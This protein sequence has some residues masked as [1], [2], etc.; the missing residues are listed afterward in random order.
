LNPFFSHFL[1]FSAFSSRFIPFLCPDAF[2]FPLN[3]RVMCFFQDRKVLLIVSLLSG[4]YERNQATMF[5]IATQTW[6]NLPSMRVYRDWAGAAVCGDNLY[7][8]GGCEDTI[9]HSSVEVFD[10]AT[11]KW[12]L[13]PT[14]MTVGRSRCTTLVQDDKLFVIGGYDGMSS[15]GSV[16]VCDM[17]THTW[18]Q[19]PSMVQPRLGCGAILH[20]GKLYVLGGYCDRKYLNTGEVFDFATRQWSPLTMQLNEPR[21]WFSMVFVDDSILVVG[22][23]GTGDKFLSSGERLDMKTQAVSALPPMPS[24][25]YCG[26]VVSEDKLYVWSDQPCVF[27][28]HTEKWT[29]LPAFSKYRFSGGVCCIANLKKSN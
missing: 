14:P 2:D 20:D 15:L 11:L 4:Q 18:T 6:S 9:T 23:G 26:G 22:G 10:F 12:T 24:P 27:D 21:I 13:L 5:D 25:N 3:V 7:V 19:L 28:L 1:P 17:E 29:Q 16:E 8:V